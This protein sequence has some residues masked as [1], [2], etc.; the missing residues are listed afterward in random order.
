VK[1]RYWIA[2]CLTLVP[3]YIF[4]VQPPKQ[5]DLLRHIKPIEVINHDSGIPGVDAIYCI[6]LDIRKEKWEAMQRRLVDQG[7]KATRVSAVNGWVEI[8]EETIKKIHKPFKARLNPGQI[9]CL[10]SHLSIL[11]DAKNRGFDRILILEDDVNFVSD[12]GAVSSYVEEVSK[13][14]TD[15]DILYLDDW[16]VARRYGREPEDRPS[17]RMS[18]IIKK[19]K[20]VLQ[21]TS[22]VKT[23]YR[24]GN[25]GYVVSKKGMQK[26]ISYFAKTPIY[27]AYDLELNH[28]PNIKMYETRQDFVTV[29]TTI[30]DTT[31]R[32]KIATCP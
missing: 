12:M 22:L 24:H 19:P 26:I 6:N 27:H 23:Y 13:C 9:G 20:E 1:A 31:N 21:G 10:L 3:V 15:W 5:A 30:S 32:P 7:L 4:V 29:I 28:I 25:Y 17:S 18:E 16:D 2:I 11:K 8:S 14:D